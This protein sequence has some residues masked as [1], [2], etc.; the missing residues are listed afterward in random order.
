MFGFLDYHN[1]INFIKYY[2]GSTIRI[3]S[4]EEINQSTR[5]LLLYQYYRIENLEWRVALAR[6]GFTE[7]ESL[8]AKTKLQ[9]LEKILKEQEIGGRIYE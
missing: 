7:Q 3:P 6:A 8:S 1:F 2:E 9:V 5:V 4:I